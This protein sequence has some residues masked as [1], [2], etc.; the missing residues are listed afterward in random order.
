MHYKIT[1][2]MFKDIFYTIGN[3]FQPIFDIMPMIADYVNYL[4][5]FI[6]FMFLVLWTNK[7]FEH[8]K[9]GEEHASQ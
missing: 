3:S 9:N 4:F 6:I 1:Q 5:M 7:M 8:R 2:F